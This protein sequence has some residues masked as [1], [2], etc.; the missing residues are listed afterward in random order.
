MAI[1]TEPQKNI[2][3]DMNDMRGPYMGEPNRLPDT[4]PEPA[5]IPEGSPEWAATHKPAPKR[6]L[7][8]GAAGAIGVHVIAHFMHNTDWEIVALDSFH[9]HH[10]GYFDR[11]TRVCRNHPEWPA[12]IKIIAHDLNAPISQR[13]IEQIGEIDYVVNLASRSDVSNSIDED[14]GTPSGASADFVRNN[15]ELMLNML[16]YA[17]VAIPAVFLHF[18]T[19][20][21]YGPAPKDSGGHKEWDPI[22]PSNPY[23]ASKA[24]QEALAIAWWRCY[25]VPLIITN[26]MNNF[27]EMQ[28][29]SKFP[30]MIQK[31]IE[32]GEV[33]DVHSAGDGQIGTRYYIHSRNTADALLFILKNVPPVM[34]GPGEIDRPVRLNIVGDKQVAN[35]ELVDII[36]KLMDKPAQCRLVQYHDFNPGHDL[37]YG[38]NGDAL[39]ELGWSSPVPFEESLKNTIE[40]QKRNP[41]WMK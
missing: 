13:E 37:H 38:L 15:T 10:K 18:S 41:E 26:T 33:I 25:G 28:A 1:T 29:P 32:A 16:E 39:K 24:V 34:H 40:W 22:V 11:I 2:G 6:V 7:L 20:E 31:R 30:A 8:T 21:V 19:D 36:S 9:T 35:D 12:R 27:G 4:T 14:P 23:S 5:K 17:R 3:G